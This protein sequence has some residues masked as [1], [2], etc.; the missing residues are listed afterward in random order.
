[1]KPLPKRDPF[2]AYQREDAA[3]RRIGPGK[4]CKCGE[5]RPEALITES[6]PV[7]CAKCRRENRG[8]TTMDEHH[9]AGKANNRATI[10][11]PVNDHRARLSPAQYDWP[12]TTRENPEGSPLLAAAAC[13]RGFADTLIYLVQKLLL[14][15][16]EMLEKLDN[17]LVDTH[18]RK[19]WLNTDF[20]RFAP[21]V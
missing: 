19:Y 16:P 12:K 17:F 13:I 10:P 9:P 14:W 7:T 20:G 5:A 2:S 1:M 4:Q 6:D 8:Q 18:G 21:G 11:L 3:A 15:I